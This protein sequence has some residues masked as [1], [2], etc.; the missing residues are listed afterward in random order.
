MGNRGTPLGVKEGTKEVQHLGVKVGSKR[1]QQSMGRTWDAGSDTRGGGHPLMCH[2]AIG[3]E[4]GRGDTPADE[5][6]CHQS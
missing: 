3:Y 5:S 6:S 4:R 1:A 2:H